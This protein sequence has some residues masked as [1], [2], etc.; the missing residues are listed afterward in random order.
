MK[1]IANLCLHVLFLSVCSSQVNVNVATTIDTTDQH[2]PYDKDDFNVTLVSINILVDVVLDTIVPRIAAAEYL[3]SLSNDNVC[4]YLAFEET[5]Q[6]LLLCLHVLTKYILPGSVH[7]P[8]RQYM[9]NTFGDRVLTLEADLGLGNLSVPAVNNTLVE[10]FASGLDILRPSIVRLYH[11]VLTFTSCRESDKAWNMHNHTLL[12]LDTY[13]WPDTYDPN[14]GNATIVLNHTTFTSKTTEDLQDEMKQYRTWD[15]RRLIHNPY[16]LG[17][18]V[19]QYVVVDIFEALGANSTTLLTDYGL[20]LSVE[21]QQASVRFASTLRNTCTDWYAI[22][23]NAVDGSNWYDARRASIH[24]KYL[25]DLTLMKTEVGDEYRDEDNAKITAVVQS[26]GLDLRKLFP[27]IVGSETTTLR[28]TSV[29]AI[30]HVPIQERALYRVV[31]L[32]GDGPHDLTSAFLHGYVVLEV[33]VCSARNVTFDLS[34]FRPLEH[35]SNHV[36]APMLR[37]VSMPAYTG[38]IPFNAFKGSVRLEHVNFEAMEGSI[39]MEAF[40]T[41]QSL[42]TVEFPNMLGGIAYRAFYNATN[43]TTVSFP[44]MNGIIANE[45]FGLCTALHTIYFPVLNNIV[46]SDAFV[47]CSNL[48][49]LYLPG[50]SNSSVVALLS[51]MVGSGSVDIYYLDYPNRSQ[52]STMYNATTYTQPQVGGVPPIPESCRDSAPATGSS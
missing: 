32:S 3:V 22:R 29:D 26:L 33:F 36:Y 30:T 16:V 38:S 42:Q 44:K 47:G 31:I 9:N 28:V 45:A 25:S 6:D 13:L 52:T 18:M 4:V 51:T 43:L 2:S 49:Q 14:T 23:A 37:S 1:N 40:S 50:A 27:S 21:D 10:L 17:L 11:D 12:L 46:T 48:H 20:S 19:M 35:N 24:P 39:G 34:S 8:V 5:V 7:E 41:R 15:T